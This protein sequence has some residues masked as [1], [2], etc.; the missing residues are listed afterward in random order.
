MHLK[1][2]NDQ[3]TDLNQKFLDISVK[4]QDGAGASNAS[5]ELTQIRKKISGLGIYNRMY[6]DFNKIVTDLH[7]CYE[8]MQDSDKEMRKMAEDDLASL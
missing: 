8:L 7:S 5:E 6:S 3:L 2:F 4:Q 1:K